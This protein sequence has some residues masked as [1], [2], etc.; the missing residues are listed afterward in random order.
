MKVTSPPILL[1]V[2]TMLFGMVW[3]VLGEEIIDFNREIRPILSENCF[4]CHGPDKAERKANLRLDTEEGAKSVLSDHAAVV[5]GDPDASALISRIYHDD[6]DEIM[7]PADSQRH[8]SVAEKKLLRAWIKQGAPWM[9]HWAFVP[10]VKADLPSVSDPTWCRNEIDRFVLAHLDQESLKPSQETETSTLIRRLH[11]DLTGLPPT[12]SEIDDSYDETIGKLFRSPR[13]AE[14]MT[15]QWL[16]AARYADTDGYQND[17]PRD[18]WRW[19]DWVIEAYEQNMPFDQFTIEQLAGDLLQP[20]PTLEQVIA[21]GFNRNHRYNSESG[22]VLEEFLL[23]N[24]V[25]RVDTTSTVWMGL[26]TGCA[27]CHDHKYDPIS[28]KEYYQLIAYFNSVPESGRAIKF[29]NSEPWIKAPT[30]VQAEELGQLDRAVL[31]AKQALEARETEI[32]RALG[33]WKPTGEELPL[34]SEKLAHHFIE[35]LKKPLGKVPGLIC[36]GRFSIAFRMTPED[37]MDGAILSN[38]QPGSTRSGILVRFRDGHLR[39]HIITRWIAGVATLETERRFTPGESIHITLTNDGT[40]RSQGMRI[41]VDGELVTTRRLHNTN[42]N[43]SPKD[44]GAVIRVGKSPHEKSWH[45]QVEDL[46]FYIERTLTQTEAELLAEP[47][48]ISEIAAISS[49]DHTEVQSK[50]LR[51]YFLEHVAAPSL[52]ELDAQLRTEESERQRAYDALPTTMVMEETSL[53]KPTSIRIRGAYD[54]HGELVSR[55]TPEAFPAMPD[56]YPKNRLGLARWLVD[57]N[58]P[59]TARVTVNRYWQLLFGRGLV[60]T[61]EDFGAQGSLPSH[62][63]LLDWL[64]V[65]FVEHGWDVQ[66]LLRKIVSSATYRQ[67]SHITQQ[68]LQRD[69]QNIHLARAPRRRLAGNVLRDQALLVSGLLVEERGGVSVKPY[70]PA[71]LWS[72][73]SNARYV[74]GKGKDLYRRSL[75]TYWKRTLAPPSMAVLDTADREQCSIRPKQTNTPLQALTLLNETAFFEAARKLGERMLAVSDS[76]EEQ[77]PFAFRAVTARFPSDREL[78]VLRKALSSYETKFRKNPEA[79][80]LALRVGDSL[81][82]ETFDSVTLAAAATLANVLLNMDETTTRE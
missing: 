28:Q 16:E 2:L 43:K 37:V 65:D 7:P 78:D 24:A 10:P 17:G 44:F 5:P 4:Q 56:A 31:A 42:S 45:G 50:K 53:P 82:D 81:P 38:E 25:D 9:K 73:A 32:T 59:L 55:G 15:W 69:P 6:P 34:F 26:T 74:I 57:G 52:G 12:S 47:L 36:N 63:E 41:F 48:L 33:N 70:Q 8:L 71:K 19:R 35:P 54:A 61:A 60:S 13:Y 80:K 49:N 23:E 64:A 22:L 21:T 66:H 29:G 1:L 46:R 39:F 18:M 30:K 14:R 79:A 58:H 40:Q 67:S 77:I 68:H 51:R 62:P 72:E 11:L 27:R 20:N 3:F 75:Y 76:P